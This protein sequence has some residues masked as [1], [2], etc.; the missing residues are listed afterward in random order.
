VPGLRTLPLPD[1]TLS[2]TFWA[3]WGCAQ[4]VSP[5][6]AGA[7]TPLGGAASRSVLI[8]WTRPGTEDFLGAQNSARDWLEPSPAPASLDPDGWLV[9]ILAPLEQRD[10]GRATAKE[11]VIHPRACGKPTLPVGRRVGR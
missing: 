9:R 11:L 7:P 6:G 10:Y 5:S 3:L 2:L 4:V 8:P 1:W